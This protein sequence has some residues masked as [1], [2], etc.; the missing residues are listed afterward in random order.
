MKLFSFAKTLLTWQEPILFNARIR[1]RRGWIL[2]GILAGVIAL[3]MFGA[4]QAEAFGPR[5]KARFSIPGGLAL[6]AF[7]GVFLTSL[8]DAPDLNRSVTIDEK[9]ISVFGNAGTVTSM[10][11]FKVGDILAVLLT[12]PEETGRPFGIMQVLTNKGTGVIG[13]PRKVPM[14]KVA[15]AVHRLGVPVQLAG[16]VPPDPAAVATPYAPPPAPSEM[17]SM[18]ARVE[19]LPEGEI[20]KI[21]TPARTGIALTMALTPLVLTVLPGL[22]LIGYGLYQWLVGGVRFLDTAPY[23]GGGFALIVVGFWFTLRYAN[24]APSIYLR[25]TIRNEIEMRPNAVLDARDDDLWYVDV[26]PRINWGKAMVKEFSDT[27]FLKVD[28]RSR[29][30]LFEGDQ[31]RWKIPAASLISAAPESYRPANAPADQDGGEVFWVAVVRANVDGEVWE[32][33]LSKCH[34][35]FAPK[36]S[37]VRQRNAEALCEAI[38]GLRPDWRS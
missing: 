16:W 4:M 34:T 31:E 17:P 12:P 5:G 15:D 29:C 18:S 10:I 14:A 28:D 30:V 2:R 32:A 26:I 20:G 22:G 8:L 33:P 3:V 24:F 36:T 13:V 37:A 9:S 21:M 38:R 7:I 19:K 23:L 25:G 35:E 6:S 27:G 1:D 11:N